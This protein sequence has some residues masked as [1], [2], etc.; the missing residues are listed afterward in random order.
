MTTSILLVRHGRTVLNAQDRL[1]GL[2]DPPLDEVGLAQAAAVADALADRDVAAVH[3]SPLVRAVATAEV[4]AARFG[5]TAQADPRFNDRDYGPWTG[6]ERAAV[7]AQFGSV[8]AA[9]GVEP[10]DTVLARVLP[11]L[12]AV[13]R[14][15]RGVVIVSHD[16]VI[17]PLVAALGSDI[18]V[19]IPTGS[20]SELVWHDGRWAVRS[21]GNMP[22]H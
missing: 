18:D 15:G 1:R 14:D 16:A 8:G 6:H 7:I 12:D 17:G 9:P 2:A 20:W 3:S 10:T 19:P 22:Q 5:L 4:I 13:R 11:A 21:V